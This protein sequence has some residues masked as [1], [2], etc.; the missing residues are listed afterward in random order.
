VPLANKA[1]AAAGPSSTL[2]KPRKLSYKEQRELDQLPARIEALEAEQRTLAEFLAQPASY[3]SEPDR[4][5][6]AQVRH[7][8]IDDELLAA[9]ERWEMLGA[10]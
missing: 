1:P 7:A 10:R 4:A 2:P 9:L 6:Q 3:A 8:A 5:M